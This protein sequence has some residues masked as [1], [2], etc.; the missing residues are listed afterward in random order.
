MMTSTLADYEQALAFLVACCAK[1]TVLLAGAWLIVV[2]LRQRSSALAPPRLDCRH[3]RLA[4]ASF[5]RDAAS[6][7]AFRHTGQRSYFLEPRA[8]ECWKL[9]LAHNSFQH[10]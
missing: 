6:R 10:Y 9:H 2:A 7:V 8:R 3:S 1:A 4:R 5:L